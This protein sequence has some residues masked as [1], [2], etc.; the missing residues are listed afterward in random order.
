MIVTSLGILVMQNSPT[1]PMPRAL[2]PVSRSPRRSRR[3]QMALACGMLS[4]LAAFASGVLA[5]LSLIGSTGHF[6]VLC[7]FGAGALGIGGL[8]LL[9][10]DAILGTHERPRVRHRLGA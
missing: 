8:T 6:A 7:I 5:L 4:Y 2:R 10:A 1:M 9:G 3:R